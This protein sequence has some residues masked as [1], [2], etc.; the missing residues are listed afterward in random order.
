MVTPGIDPINQ[1][2]ETTDIKPLRFKINNTQVGE[3]NPEYNTFPEELKHFL[4]RA[5]TSPIRNQI[6]TE[7]IVNSRIELVNRQ[8]KKIEFRYLLF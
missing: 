1:F 6:D 4:I 8:L 3:L 7:P 5:F 2:I